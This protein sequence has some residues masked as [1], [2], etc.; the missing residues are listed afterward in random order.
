M[1]KSLLLL[2][3]YLT[4]KAHFSCKALVML[5]LLFLCASNVSR[6]QVYYL[7]SDASA[8]SLNTDDALNRMNYDGTSN[9]RMVSSFSNSPVRIEQDLANSRLFIYEGLAA[10]KSIKVVNSGTGAITASI[11]VPYN[12]SCMR[13]DAATDYIYFTT[14]SG[15]IALDVSDAI[16]KVKPTETTPTLIAS[17]ITTSPLFLALDVANSR[18]FIYESV[19]ANR[20]IKTFDLTSKTIT[21]SATINAGTVVD[22]AYDS[23]TGYIYYLTNDGSATNLGATDALNK[24]LPGASTTIVIKAQVTGSPGQ[25][26]LLDAGNNRAYIYEALIANRAIKAVNLTTGDVT[27][28]LSLTSYPNAVT[29]SAMASAYVPALTTTAASGITAASATLGG[30]VTRTDAAVSARGVVYS[31]SNQT[32]TIADNKTTNGSGTGIFSASI[33]G[34]SSSTTYYARSYATSTAGTG[35]G[36]VVTFATPSNDATLSAFSISSGTL[37]PTFAAATTS[38]TASVTN[39]TTSITVTPTR[40]QANA[41]IKVNNTT[42]TSGSASGNLN[43]SIGDNV[44]STVVTAQDGTTTKTYTTTV[45]RPKAVQTITFASTNSKTFGNVDFAAGGSASSGL[46]VS[47]SSSNTAVA[48]VS[49]ST[50]HIVGAGSTT[51]TASQAGDASY[52]AATS[53][54]QTLTVDKA[55]QTITFGTITAKT[56]GTADFV[57]GA[58]INSPLPITYASDNTAVATI[59]SNQVH[60]VGQGTA[61]ITASQA[62]TTNYNAAANV[63]QNFTV[64]KANLTITAAAKTKVYGDSDPAFTYTATGVVASDAPT[65]ALSRVLPNENKFI[66]TY[67][68]DQSTLSYGNNYNVTYVGANLTIN[69]RPVTVLPVAKTKVY[70]EVDPFLN[71]FQIIAGSLAPGDATG[72]QFGRAPGENVGTYL[73]TLGTKK[74]YSNGSSGF[75]EITSNYDVTVQTA[76]V[77]ITAKPVTV[78]AS[79]QTKTY[80]DADPA[81][82]YSTDV[83]LAFSDA[84]TGA[85]SRAAGENFG[86]YAINKNT[87]ALSSNYALTYTTNNLT[88]GKKTINVT[89][90]AKNKTYGDTDPALTYTADAALPNGE[91]FTGAISRA[92]GE[93]FSTYAIGQ[94][95]LALSSNYTLNFTGSN[96]TID[97][98]AINVAAVANSKT[99]GDTDPALTYTADALVAGDTYSGNV[100]RATGEAAGDYPIGQGTLAVS[101]AASYALNY[102]PA[103]FTINKRA[104]DIYTLSQDVQFGNPDTG[105]GYYYSGTVASG[106]ALSGA[107]G[108]TPGTAI[109]TYATTL[110]TLAITNGASYDLVFHSA[111]Y[112]IIQREVV[113]SG[114]S[115]IKIYGDADPAIN[116]SIVSGSLLGG[117][118]ITGALA[119]DAGETAGPYNVTQGTLA[120]NDSNYKLT[121]QGGYFEVDRSP[122]TITIDNKTKVATKAN[123]ALTYSVSGY[124]NGDAEATTFLAPISLTTDATI[125]SAAG[126]Y[127]IYP[128]GSVNAS[129]Y[130]VTT[131]GGTL[132]VTPASTIN[133]LASATLNGGGFNEPFDPATDFYTV[134]TPNGVPSATLVATITDPLSTMT[135][136]AYPAVAVP[137]A[138]GTP[139][140]INF[141]NNNTEQVGV[142]VTAED[143]SIKSYYFN[144]SPIPSDSKL[145]NLVTS[146]GIMTPSFDPNIR[147]YALDVSA[148]TDSVTIT[149]T[150]HDPLA[151]ARVSGGE[152]GGTGPKKVAL[153]E[154][155]NVKSISAKSADGTSTT[156]Y[157]LVIKRPIRLKTLTLSAGHLSPAFDPNVTSY[158]AKVDLATPAITVTPMGNQT[159]FQ[160]LVNGDYVNYG[161]ASA[162]VT[163]A[164]D[165]STTIA[166]KIT[167]GDGETTK[168]YTINVQH[169]S[170]DATLSG[171]ALST[172]SLNPAFNSTD[173]TYNVALPNSTTAISFTPTATEPNATIKVNNAPLASGASVTNSSLSVGVHHYSIA[174]TAADGA[175]T[176]TYTL[177]ITRAPSNQSGLANILL[178]TGTLSPVF[179]QLA[180]NSYTVLVPNEIS[181]IAITPSLAD[182]TGSLSATLNGSNVALSA[183]VITAP[184]N[185]GANSVVITSLAQD[186]T[187]MSVNTLTVTRAADFTLSN[188]TLSSGSLSPGFHKNTVAYTATV[189]NAVTSL[190]LTPTASDALATVKVN[191]TISTNGVASGPVTLLPGA[192]NIAVEVTATDGGV[193]TYAVTVTR[194]KS[195]YLSKIEFTPSSTV[196]RIGTSNNF[197]TSVSLSLTTIRLIPTSVEASSTILVNGSAVGS[198]L[199][200]DPI[201]LNSGPTVITMAVTAPD[202]SST[203]NYTVT[204]NKSGSSNAYLS[205]IATNPLSPLTQV[206]GPADLNYTATVGSLASTISLT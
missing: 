30:N 31:S 49:G 24:I 148:E 194:L 12:V 89:A 13:Y 192:N 191:G 85:L 17:S 113:V 159:Y 34:L 126:D 178:S 92:A 6:A 97:K 56:Y 142:H 130:N 123:P 32:P 91:S 135:I 182:T 160:M 4:R 7:T 83:S 43:L 185:I 199:A 138:S 25:C 1:E 69:K 197:T 198:G 124:R 147:F 75:I 132:T 57:T 171:I 96:F 19:P 180:G 193:K 39:A 100:E 82:T 2:Q 127:N 67:T 204:V 33:T 105:I 158:V 131:V 169:A 28:V 37:T 68:I 64:N 98:K 88:I 90:D 206:S 102:T 59:V 16:Y 109:G 144:V 195:A 8:S 71:Q 79:A 74:F 201:T 125:N 44:I 176:K 162:P 53:A 200:S 154:G 11:S 119:R 187:T 186:G 86:T 58:T 128:V 202:G 106:D 146:T 73:M 173:T 116:Y 134:S 38:Y 166:V 183:G 168:T 177:S 164:E 172:G 167:A 156:L 60:I 20:G 175:T 112:N 117:T 189:A 66:G 77:T 36:P 3:L 41:I 47:Y 115:T 143:G 84:F 108:R 181:S 21:A 51:I 61:N 99:F 22:I 54:T 80:G 121:F 129:N 179:D 40:N 205:K 184:L 150:T 63:V 114:G 157:T 35:Y 103:N 111:P 55:A 65:G 104:I 29:V 81:L 152:G 153:F 76:Y 190:T 50:I 149:P 203:Q 174:V 48:T 165:G 27:T 155:T 9:T 141:T 137:I 139:Y 133:T 10:Q 14:T 170:V 196:T 87:L 188:L 107:P 15:G 161:D 52:L 140:T 145:S 151:T 5:V 118:T 122:L 78:T 110:G 46:T 18:V 163:I 62:G 23:P 94:N 72:D 26:M 70:G 136:G 95:S 120:I 42:V 93:T 45:N 101:N